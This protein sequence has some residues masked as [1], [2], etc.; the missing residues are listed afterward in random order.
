MS[1]TLSYFNMISSVN[2]Y[3]LVCCAL[4]GWSTIFRWDSFLV[5]CVLIS[6]CLPFSVWLILICAFR[7]PPHCSR[8]RYISRWASG[9][10]TLLAEARPPIKLFPT[11]STSKLLHVPTRATFVSARGPHVP[12]KELLV[13]TRLAF[14]PENFSTTWISFP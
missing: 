10:P 7:S 13:T 8:R 3:P 9:K 1:L 6:I 12:P 4:L 14:D 5:K 2:W 11:F